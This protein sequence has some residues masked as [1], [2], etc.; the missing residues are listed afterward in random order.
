MAERIVIVRH[1]ETDWSATGQHTGRTDIPL[2]AAGEVQAAA[3]RPLLSRFS[4]ERVVSSPLVRARRTA[5][6][7]GYGARLA[8]SPLLAEVDYGDDEGRTRAQIR[9]DRPDWDFFKDGPRNGETIE[10]AAARAK[11]LLDEVDDV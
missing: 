1:G 7:A 11:R 8:V 9:A 4:F 5:E 2:N 6:L 10:A 3:L